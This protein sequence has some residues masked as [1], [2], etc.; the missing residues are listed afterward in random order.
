[1][2]KDPDGNIPEEARERMRGK[3]FLDILARPKHREGKRPPPKLHKPWHGADNSQKEFAVKKREEVQL[4]QREHA[5]FTEWLRGGQEGGVEA[6]AK[7]LNKSTTFCKEHLKSTTL[8]WNL[9]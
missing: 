2:G 8:V 3:N 4:E 5:E 6:V 9:V 1:M 7:K